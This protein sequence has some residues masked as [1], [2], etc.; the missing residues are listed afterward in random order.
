MRHYLA[1]A[2]LATIALAGCGSRG[3][4]TLP[5]QPVAMTPP[6]SPAAAADDSSTAPASAEKPSK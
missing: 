6:P 2:L 4:L 1:L 5:P 3:S